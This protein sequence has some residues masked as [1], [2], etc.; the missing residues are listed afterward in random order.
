M[1]TKM[2]AEAGGLRTFAIILETGDE[3]MASLQAFAERE[4]LTAAHFSAIGAFRA[5]VISYFDWE[6]KSYDKIPVDEQVEV[7]SLSGDVALDPRGKPAIHV[8]VV[9]GRRDG[10][11]LAGHLTKGEVRPTLE[12]ILTETPAHLHKRVDEESGLALIR[13]ADRV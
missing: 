6:R 4:Q 13:I 5:A 9:L 12:I 3:A 10:T 1:Q 11:A 8:H 7:A 2:L